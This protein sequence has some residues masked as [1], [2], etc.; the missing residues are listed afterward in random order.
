MVTI[1][2]LP[3]EL[4]ITENDEAEA[5]ADDG[6]DD[7]DEGADDSAVGGK[8]S[9]AD[10][11]HLELPRRSRESS[12]SCAAPLEEAGLNS[13]T[14][15]PVAVALGSLFSFE[16]F[17]VANPGATDKAGCFFFLLFSRGALWTFA[18]SAG[19]GATF[20]SRSRVVAA[21]PA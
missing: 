8:A 5:A 15:P 12:R 9:W 16:G 19:D 21:A 3:L 13:P 18:T 4:E 2:L 7:D 1:L 14:S 6:N 20:G 17:L 10:P 11:H